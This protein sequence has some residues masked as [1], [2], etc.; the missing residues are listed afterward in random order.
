M[1]QQQGLQ[2]PQFL[3]PPPLLH[4]GS[5]L[6]AQVSLLSFEF[7]RSFILMFFNWC[8]FFI[9]RH[10]VNQSWTSSTTHREVVAATP[11]NQM[12][13]TLFDCL[14]CCKSWLVVVLCC[15][16]L[17]V[18]WYYCCFMFSMKICAWGGVYFWFKKHFWRVKVTVITSVGQG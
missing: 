17:Y 3:P 2:M 15:E 13:T 14:L 6:S 7:F 12:T 9:H 11:T 16:N 18:L 5:P 8:M 1:P 10:P 4:F